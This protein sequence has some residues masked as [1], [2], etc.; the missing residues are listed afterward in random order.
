MKKLMLLLIMIIAASCLGASISYS[1]GYTSGEL[2]KD[3]LRHFLE[4]Q[5]VEEIGLLRA[6]TIVEPDNTTIYIANDNVLA[7]RAL[8]VLGSPLASKVLTKLNNEYGG[9]WNGKVDILLGRDIPDTFYGDYKEYLGEINGYTIMYEKMNTSIVLKDWYEYA[10]LLVYHALDRLLWGSRPEAEQTFLNLTKM[11]DGYGFYDIVVKDYEN[12]TGVR[13]YQVYKCAL[14]VYL[15]RALNYAGSSIIHDYKNI[16]DKCLWIISK[17]QDPVYGGIHTDYRVENG[18][19]IIQGDMNVE[20]TS[21]VVLALYS[22]YPRFIGENAKPSSNVYIISNV[23]EITYTI[24]GYSIMLTF[25]AG[26]TRIFR[27]AL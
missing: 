2:N 3:M 11:W 16:Y 17:A 19:I 26:V 22:D 13:L 24:A 7:A 14:F 15:Y 4:E 6:S 25:L 1:L 5:Y 9:G 18:K 12:K 8:A 21:I 23:Y 20:T 27:K 10:D